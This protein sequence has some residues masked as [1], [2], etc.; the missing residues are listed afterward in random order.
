MQTY[1][2][3]N[4][5]P[6]KYKW[7]TELY[8]KN[9][10]EYQAAYQKC[11]QQIALFKNYQNYIKNPQKLYEFL[12][13]LVDV[14]K[15]EG[16]L[17]VYAMAL[18]DQ[19]LG[20][21]ENAAR[22]GALED[23]ICQFE[24][25]TNFFRSELLKLSKEE[26]ASLFSSEPKLEE[27]R[28]FLDDIYRTKEHVL[29]DEEEILLT[30]M[31]SAVNDYESTASNLLN[32]ENNYGKI[33]V[34][35]ET[36]LISSTNYRKLKRGKD[37]TV[38]KKA[39]QSFEKVIMQYAGTVA[40]LLNSYVKLDEKTAKIRHFSG[41]WEEYLFSSKLTDKIFR[42][43]TDTVFRNL[44]SAQEFYRMKA[45]GLN[46]KYLNA[47]DTDVVLHSYKQEISIEEATTM[48]REAI[49]PL[50]EEYVKKFDEISKKRCIDYCQYK[51]KWSGGYC[52][53]IPD[54]M[55]LILM[56][57]HGD[58]NSVF[59]IAHEC[60]HHVHHQFMMDVLPAEYQSNERIVTEIPSLSNE[61]LLYFYLIKHAKTKEEK[62]SVIEKVM[63]TINNNFF[64]AVREGFMEEEMHQ[65]VREGNTITKDYMRELTLKSYEQFTG[66][67]VKL[68][69]LSGNSWARRTHYYDSFYLYSYAV[70]ISV[71]C[72]IV[73]KILDGDTEM[74]QKYI[75]FLQTGTNVSPMEAAAILGIDLE[76]EKVYQTTVDFYNSLVQ[77]YYKI[78][79]EGE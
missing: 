70:N 2:N 28:A 17:E 18:D 51:G 71:A 76:D 73:P 75:K 29:S 77:E 7:N 67:A 74:L 58:L 10:E 52:V 23:L 64:D 48:I 66:D 26:Y 6:V 35:G 62:L 31:L 59:T 61:L 9:E 63:D 14:N 55:P 68:D 15:I 11:Q 38:R 54:Y 20:I 57:Y 45:K 37:A 3:R 19:E 44:D 30:E 50:G 53:S 21:P 34:N 69:K 25:S 43:L 22:L 78:L 4:E 24:V 65:Y 8:F 1:Q 16:C 5:V 49:K 39:Y 36:I 27:Y 60:G 33:K 79:E 46:Q 41:S 40:S 42:S 32:Q 72:N 12:N 47:F 56:S 13:L